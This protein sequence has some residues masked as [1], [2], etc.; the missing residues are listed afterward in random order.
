MATLNQMGEPVQE[1]AEW[2]QRALALAAQGIGLASPNPTV[3]C[4]IVK[5]SVQ[6]G[7][8]FHLYD[9]K[10][11]AEVVALRE[12]GGR[13]RGATAYVTLEP[14]SYQGR[15]GPCTDALITAG[16]SRVVIATQDPNPRVS[17]GGV[18]KLFH[19]DIAV[20][21]GTGEAD[22]RLLN[23]AFAKYV[24]TGVPFVTQKIAVS[25]DGRIAPAKQA[26]GA[27]Q[28]VT[29]ELAR[30]EVQHMRHAAD[31]VLTGIGT[32]LADDPLLTDR[33]GR[34]RRRPLMRIVLDSELR[35]PLESQLVKTMQDDLILFTIKDDDKLIGKLQERGIRVE[36]V[37]D[38][39]GQLSLRQVLLRIG[40]LGMISVL[41]EAGSRLNAALL[42]A[43]VTD[44]IAVFT[45]P[46]LLG[47][48]AVPAFAA[49][50]PLDTIRF[51]R[52]S[53]ERFGEDALFTGYVRDPWAGVG[54]Q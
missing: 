22:A 24:L 18:R 46:T 25:L 3:G 19:A 41:A 47:G 1:D 13:A 51:A 20:D 9:N 15:T 50:T 10:D 43:Q 36:V 52:P 32:V 7:A 17:G 21:V 2:M 30:V 5:D 31:A 49:G 37:P 48:D 4:V 6:V 14:C 27:D 33:S 45:A 29:G 11:H 26:R 54:A 16:V 39:A 12:A 40:G 35:L 53:F 42:K 44:K 23:D 38:D 28:H 8:G 34:V